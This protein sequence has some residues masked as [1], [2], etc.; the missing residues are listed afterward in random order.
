KGY[1]SQLTSSGRWQTPNLEELEPERLDLRKHAVQR[2][3]VWER[4]RQHGVPPARLSLQAR[5]REANR[6]AQVAADSDAVPVRRRIVVWTGHV[7]TMHAVNR[8]AAQGS[9]PAR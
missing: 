3:A 5:E 6:L 2:G 7:L 4:P 1:A 9:R 8:P